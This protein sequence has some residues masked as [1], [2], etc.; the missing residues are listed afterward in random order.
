[1]LAAAL[2]AALVSAALAASPGPE[3]GSQASQ[4]LAIGAVLAQAHD[5][6]TMLA[7]AMV[8]APNGQL[9]IDPA[10]DPDAAELARRGVSTQLRV[11]V[12]PPDASL[13]VWLV[14]PPAP[15]AGAPPAGRGTIVFLHGICSSRREHLGHALHVASRGYT[16]VL[17]DLRG[18]GRST[19]QWLTYGC[20]EANDLQQLLSALLARGLVTPPVGALG[21]SYGAATA[22]LWAS[23]DP[24]LGAVVS[25]ASYTS[26]AEVVPQYVREFAPWLASLLGPERIR[27]AIAAAGRVAAFDPAT[28][29]P[30]AAIARR[31]VPTLLLHGEKDTNIPFAQAQQLAAAARGPC[32]L[33]AVPGGGHQCASSG[34]VRA[35]ADEWFAR[36]LGSA[37]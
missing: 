14:R 8:S 25:V 17:P 23:Q 19:G 7:A 26:M 6:P 13:L 31:R 30:L 35:Q 33:L 22:N 10:G 15:P 12:G 18:Q 2:P 5:V 36:W 32:R 24:R 29:S 4:A 1:V 11:P 28:A 20:Q 21:S 3:P 34:F 37:P 9:E 16:A 27:E